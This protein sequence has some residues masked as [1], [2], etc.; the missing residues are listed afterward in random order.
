MLM[1]AQIDGY[2]NLY[3]FVL[4]INDIFVYSKYTMQID[5]VYA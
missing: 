5:C 3:L 4:H 1:I 2:D